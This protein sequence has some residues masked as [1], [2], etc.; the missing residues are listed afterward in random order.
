[1]SKV[2]LIREATTAAEDTPQELW[3]R[4]G[5][6]VLHRVPGR[7]V[8]AGRYRTPQGSIR[9]RIEVAPSA[10]PAQRLRFY[11]WSEGEKTFVPQCIR[12]ASVEQGILTL[13]SVLVPH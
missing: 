6:K 4:W 11:A 1:M 12:A 7:T 2:K 8:L 9:G 5:W 10:D 3:E 13:E